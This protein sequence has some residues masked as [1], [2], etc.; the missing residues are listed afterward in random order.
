MTETAQLVH[1]LLESIGLPRVGE[2][3][4]QQ[5]IKRVLM[6]RD[7]ALWRRLQREGKT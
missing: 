2:E 3:T 5:H 4:W 6:A 1:E 7:P